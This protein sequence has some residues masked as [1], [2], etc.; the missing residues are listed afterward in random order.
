M[1]G[2][3]EEIVDIGVLCTFPK[4]ELGMEI[5]FCLADLKVEDGTQKF[6][7]NDTNLFGS[8]ATNDWLQNIKLQRI[9]ACPYSAY[10]PWRCLTGDM[11]HLETFSP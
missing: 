10:L 4:K 2:G 5:I 7:Q 8:V 11:M 6:C 3:G 9:L 1:K